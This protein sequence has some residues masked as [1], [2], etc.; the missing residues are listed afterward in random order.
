MHSRYA[1]HVCKLTKLS[2]EGGQVVSSENIQMGKRAV[3]L[4]GKSKGPNTFFT[5]IPEF[6]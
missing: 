1:L 3:L 5:T 4:H 2:I 6:P